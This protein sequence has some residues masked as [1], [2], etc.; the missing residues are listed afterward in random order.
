MCDFPDNA[1]CT[2]GAGEHV[3]DTPDVEAVVAEFPEWEE[4]ES[5]PDQTPASTTKKPSWEDDYEYKPWQPPTPAPR[6]DY[7]GR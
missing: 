2:E 7:D 6:P 3:P 4:V 5:V 1:G